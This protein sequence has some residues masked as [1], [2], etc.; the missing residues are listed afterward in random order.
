MKIIFGYCRVSTSKQNIDLQE[1]NILAQYPTAKIYKEKFTGTKFQSRNELDKILS[2]V[3]SGDTIVF[4]SVSRM[5]RNTNEGIELY[6]KLFDKGIELVFLKEPHVNTETY[7]KALNSGVE[8]IG[9]DIADIYLKATNKVL[10]LL[11][12]QQIELAF[13]QA[14]KEVLDLHQRTSEGIETARRAGK[15]IGRQKGDKLIIKKAIKAKKI[16]AANSKTFGGSLND[17]E[18]ARAAGV[19]RKTYYKYKKEL[20]EEIQNQ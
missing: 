14:E 10:K 7:K 20:K 12:T 1:R 16:I 13:K 15:Q 11:A 8:L 2:Q 18:C 6:M 4:D 17:E 3:Q 19:S 5:S 9:N